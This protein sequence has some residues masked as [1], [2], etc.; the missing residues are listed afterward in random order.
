VA[1]S[2]IDLPDPHIERRALALVPRAAVVAASHPLAVLATAGDPVTAA[3]LADH[4]Q[5]V[6]ED[7]S[8]LTQDRDFNVLS[9]GTWRVGDNMT[10]HALILAGIG[11][12]NLPLWLVER[13][14]GKVGSCGFPPRISVRKAK[15]RHTGPTSISAP[16]H[17]HFATRCCAWPA[18]ERWP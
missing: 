1:I 4:V 17:V 14:L 8:P 7:P 16:P 9:P 3:D 18:T 5:V 2:G 10:K 11:W 13:D 6:A 15:R 12:G